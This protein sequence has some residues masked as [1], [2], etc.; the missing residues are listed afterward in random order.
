MF[1]HAQI[2]TDYTCQPPTLSRWLPIASLQLFVWLLLRPSAWHHYIALIDPQL[3]ADFPLAALR[4]RHWRHPLLWRLLKIS[5]FY[6]LWIAIILSLF[7]ALSGQPWLTLLLSISYAVSLAIV[8]GLMSAVTI[9]LPFAILSSVASGI[10]LGLLTG[11]TG[12]LHSGVAAVSFFVFVL[13]FS[14]TALSNLNPDRA[15]TPLTR[16]IGS[17]VVGVLVGGIML[18]GVVGLA[19]LASQGLLAFLTTGAAFIYAYAGITGLVFGLLLGIILG[20][21][22]RCWLVAVPLGL[23]TCLGMAGIIGGLWHSLDSLE[24]LGSLHLVMGTAAGMA[25]AMILVL[26]FALAYSLA[27][28]IANNWAG[29]IAGVLMVS[30]SAYLG[31][32]LFVEHY[33]VLDFALGVGAALILG[34]SWPLWQPILLYPLTAAWDL[35]LYQTEQRRLP[36]EPSLFNWHSVCWDEKQ[37]LPIVGLE[38]YLVHIAEQ[39]PQ[40]GES[41]LAYVSTTPQRHAAQAA[42]IELDAR[43]LQ[44][45]LTL[46]DVAA[47]HQLIAVGELSGPA[48]SVLRS[49]GRLSRD[50]AAALSQTSAYNQRLALQAIEE[51]LDGLLRELTRSSEPY[52][53]RFRNVVDHWRQLVA[54]RINAYTTQ[55]ASEIDNP[56]TIGLPLSAQQ[57]IFVGRKDISLKIEQFL[58][59]NPCP[60]LLLYG[61]RRMGKTSLLNNLNR[62][63]PSTIVPLFIDLQGPVSLTTDTAG[64]LYNL[65]R[66]MRHS[67]QQQRS[68]SLP[69]LSRETINLDPI[70]AFYEWLD[71]VDSALENNTLLLTLDEFVALDQAFQEQRLSESVI[72]GFFRHLIQHRPQLKVLLSGSHTLKEFEAWSSY[73]INVQTIH[74]N[75]LQTAEAQRLIEQPIVDFGLVYTPEAVDYVL[76]LTRCH[77][78]LVQLLCSEIVNLKNDQAPA[79]RYQVTQADVDHAMPKALQNGNFFFADIESNQ[80]TPQGAAIL[81][82]IAQHEGEVTFST[83]QSQFPETSAMDLD[84]LLQREVLEV[85]KTGYAFAVELIRHWFR[86]I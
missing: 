68:Y 82:F 58:R 34:L 81:G 19:I 48:S 39:N 71:E 66:E 67:A 64:F 83:L 75:Y 50:I 27:K 6:P 4:K 59:K 25:T 86:R 9:A 36:N 49:F 11:L 37:Y 1:R 61:Q 60:P 80:I 72:L 14:G 69:P 77:P 31:L 44:R 78:Y 47:T 30:V 40:E 53:Q 46:E 74:I 24:N 56:Y 76:T 7:L 65:S 15:K 33:A 84:I 10:V 20:F 38:D 8:S 55:H 21:Y 23:V 51:R 35:L 79:H 22:T 12:Q 43:Y 16:Q 3:P 54:A 26:L 57:E 52:A 62:L 18:L 5:L 17:I 29:V 85:T 73:L 63:L 13:S 28:N 41:V 45:C 42:Q 2:S 32:P 70:T